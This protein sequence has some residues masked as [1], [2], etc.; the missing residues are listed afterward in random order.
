MDVFRLIETLARST[1]PLGPGEIRSQTGIA[2]ATLNRLLR[3]C[4]EQGYVQRVG[5][6][7]YEAGPRLLSLAG[8]AVQNVRALRFRRLLTG[9][10][11]ETGLNAELYALNV[12]GPTFLMGVTGRG[13]RRIPFNEGQLIER[14]YEHPAGLYFL[15]RY[16]EA[17]EWRKRQMQILDVD[18]AELRR[19]VEVAVDACIYVER[20]RLQPELA[21]AAIPNG[22]YAYCLCLA[23]FLSDFPV[24]R[25][26]SLKQLLRLRLRTFEE[27]ITELENTQKPVDVAASNGLP[28]A[29]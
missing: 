20:G 25:E 18:V 27:M 23:G 29:S 19:R 16:P 11:E 5:H 14:I 26:E 24:A 1:R 7:S 13:E 6:G 17:F 15:Q 28:K 12:K 10:A 3:R 21:R 4:Q 8:D 2:P 22:D 9:L